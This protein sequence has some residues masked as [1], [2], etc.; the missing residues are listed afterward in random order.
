MRVGMLQRVL[1]VWLIGSAMAW[2]YYSST[3]EQVAHGDRFRRGIESKSILIITDMVADIADKWSLD[4]LKKYADIPPEAE[5]S[6]ES[7]FASY[8]RLGSIEKA[9]DCQMKN[10]DMRPLVD[11]RT[12]TEANYF[13]TGQFPT[14][15][16]TIWVTVFDFKNEGFWRISAINVMSNYFTQPKGR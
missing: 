5:S 8:K 10:Y 4:T 15:P 1:V 2:L 16:A 3:P 11:G 9:P 6:Y 7:A 12:Y 14:G 13:C